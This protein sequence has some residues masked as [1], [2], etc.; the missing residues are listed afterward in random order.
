MEEKIYDCGRISIVYNERFEERIYKIIVITV[1]TTN[2]NSFTMKLQFEYGENSCDIDIEYYFNSVKV[3]ENILISKFS[4]DSYINSLP[5]DGGLLEKDKYLDPNFESIYD[6][7][8]INLYDNAIPH[9]AKSK[10]ETEEIKELL[11]NA[12][13]IITER[14]KT[15]I[16][17]FINYDFTE[18]KQNNIA[19]T[20][21][22]KK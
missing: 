6:E 12:M 22:S 5:N 18:E 11:E 13:N 1:K 19:R 9:N 17:D 7:I 2:K 10:E 3:K 21:K 4:W 8:I 15:F 14:L 20:L 16:E